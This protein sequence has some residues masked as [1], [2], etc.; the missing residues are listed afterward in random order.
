MTKGMVLAADQG[1]RLLRLT[2][3]TPDP[4]VPIRRK[5]MHAYLTESL[6]NH[7][8]RETHDQFGLEFGVPLAPTRDGRLRHSRG[9]VTSRET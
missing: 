1:S 8:I 6:T 4:M 9:F 5:P 2:Q 7:G 3:K